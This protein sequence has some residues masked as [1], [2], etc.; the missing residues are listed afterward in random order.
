MVSTTGVCVRVCRLL[1]L[2]LPL[3][4]IF[5]AALLAS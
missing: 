2:L 5:F 3:D 1:L 4:T